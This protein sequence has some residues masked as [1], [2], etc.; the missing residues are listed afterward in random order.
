MRIHIYNNLPEQYSTMIKILEHRTPLPTVED[1][2]DALRRD[3]QAAG[4]K[5]EIG[6]EAIGSTLFSRGRYRGCGG[7]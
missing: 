4:L 7:Y 2:M 5:K 6:D 3:E 1:A